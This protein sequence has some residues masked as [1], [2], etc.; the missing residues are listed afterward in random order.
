MFCAAF[1][2][3][4]KCLPNAG[5]R[6]GGGCAVGGAGDGRLGRQTYTSGR[7]LHGFPYCSP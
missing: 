6:K 5:F 4:F 7:H 3:K 2:V 1:N